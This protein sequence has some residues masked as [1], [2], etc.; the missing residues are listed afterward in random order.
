VTCA[1]CGGDGEVEVKVTCPSCG[2]SGYVT[3]RTKVSIASGIGAA[4]IVGLSGLAIIRRKKP[5]SKEKTEQ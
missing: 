2:G 3:D 4:A 5:T 1:E